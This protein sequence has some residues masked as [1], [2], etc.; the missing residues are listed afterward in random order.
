MWGG[1]RA[2][3]YKKTGWHYRV[4]REGERGEGNKLMQEAKEVLK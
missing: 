1:R 4:E 2:W 3:I